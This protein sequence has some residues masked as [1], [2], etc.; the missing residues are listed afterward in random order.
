MSAW[1]VVM[2][3]GWRAWTCARTSADTMEIY[4]EVDCQICQGMGPRHLGMNCIESWWILLKNRDRI[5]HINFLGDAILACPRLQDPLSL[6]W[7][8]MVFGNRGENACTNF[9]HLFAPCCFQSFC[10]MMKACVVTR[11][12][13]FCSLPLGHVAQ[14][15]GIIWAIGRGSPLLPERLVHS[16][17]KDGKTVKN[18]QSIPVSYR[19][20]V[21]V[22]IFKNAQFIYFKVIWNDLRCL[23]RDISSYINSDQVFWQ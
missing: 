3:S 12:V 10:V 2:S 19:I 7:F 21:T 14:K 17:E 11:V 15:C 18:H 5:D 9:S 8:S 23:F 6:P 20:R 13:M 16:L 22:E 1:H 4:G